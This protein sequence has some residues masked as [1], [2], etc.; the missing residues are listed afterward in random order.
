M[1]R[2]KELIAP[3]FYEIHQDLKEKKH[4]HYWLKGGRGS[5]KSSFISIEIVLGMMKDR[6]ANAVVL[7]KVGQTLQGSVYEQLQ[8]AVQVL[9]VEAFWQ[10]KINPLQMKYTAE[11]KENKIV[12]RGADKPK[13]IKSTKFRKGYCKYV[14]YEEVD[15]FGGMEE[16]R[17]INQSLLRGGEDFC[18]FY[19]YN[20]PKSQRNWVNEEILQQRE[21]RLVHHSTYLTVPKQ[22]LGEPFFI[23]AQHLQKVKPDSY[24]HEYLGEVIGTGGEVFTNITIKEITEEEMIRFDHIAR[25]IDWGYAADPFHYTVNHYDKTRKRLYIFYEIQK[26]NLSNK[27]AAEMIKAENKNNAMIVCDSAEPKSIAEM[28]EYGL[29]V[30]GAKKGADSID[31]GIKWLQDLEEIVIDPKRCPNTAR[32]FM[33][34]EIERDSNGNLKGKFPDKNNHS[35][36]AVRYSREYDMKHVRVI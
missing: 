4:T 26:L 32:E 34:Y 30:M 6:N 10:S 9:G 19:S 22:W 21:D 13:K 31:Y 11:G 12:F 20:P 7:R 5:T 17:N 14:W 35:I 18:V 25:G 16:I 8:W 23:E 1:I 15:E 27:K 2:L 36:D 3:S 33:E 24:R 28:Y 29:K